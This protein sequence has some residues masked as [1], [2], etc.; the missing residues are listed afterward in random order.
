MGSRRFSFVQGMRAVSERC[1]G[2]DVHKK[3]VIVC[4]LTNEGKEIRAFGTV[5]RDLFTLVEWVRA[6]QIPGV[7]MESTEVVR[8][9]TLQ[10]AG[11][12][13]LPSWWSRPA[14]RGRP[15]AR[16]RMSRTRSRLPMRLAGKACARIKASL[17]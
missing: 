13:R 1:C 4:V 8:K 11:D 9:P 6:H 16:R 7:V 14:T 15:Q 17:E 12:G 2:L 3:T 5:D 10:C